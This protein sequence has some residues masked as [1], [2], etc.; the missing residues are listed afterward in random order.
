MA[1][2]P[3]TLIPFPQGQSPVPRPIPSAINALSIAA[4]TAESMTVPAGAKFVIFSSNVDFYVN[5]YTTATVPGD[6]TDSTGSELNPA[7]Y[8]L[9]SVDVP[10]ISIISATAGIVTGAFYS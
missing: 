5:C 1:T 3:A 6:T 9:P 10:T 7:G 4:S 8:M 2:R